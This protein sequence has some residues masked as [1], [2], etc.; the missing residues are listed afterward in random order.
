MTFSA[1][2]RAACQKLVELALD[3]DLDRAGDRSTA[4]TIPQDLHGSAV[5]RARAPGVI[6]GLPAVAVVLAAVDARMEFCQVHCDGDRV[7][8][9]EELARVAGRV[10]SIFASERIALNFLQHLS[11][12]ATRTREYVDRV[13]P[14]RCQIL[15]TRKT[16]PGWRKLQKYAVRCGGGQNHRMGLF[17]AILIKDNHLAVL[18][19]NGIARSIA[20]VRERFGHSLPI[21]VEVDDLEQLDEALAAKPDVILLD[22]MTPTLLREAI[23]RR[24]LRSPAVLLEASGG[25]SLA[26]VEDIA[27]TGVDRISVGE[28]THS[29]PALDIALDYENS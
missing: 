9:G 16:L 4:A 22:N 8:S 14:F 19:K 28:L 12:I 3:E 26:T 23:G 25:I 24:A 7:R 27:A 29:A 1:S 17:D 2:E 18:G 15:D 21:T 6:A 13:A 11:G 5:F 10:P 20:T